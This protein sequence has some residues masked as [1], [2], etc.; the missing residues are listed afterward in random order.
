MESLDNI[1]SGKGEALPAPEV[2]EE[3]VAAPEQSEAAP[4]AEASEG[5]NQ[6][7]VP[8][9]ALHAEKQKVKRYTE[10]VADFRKQL[11]ESN[12]NWE[13]RIAQIL[14]SNKPAQ[15]QPQAP[16]F[17]ENPVEAT[18]HTVAPQFEQFS[19]QLLAIAKDNAIVRFTEE[20]VN[21]AEG[22]FLKAM[23]SQK[24]D[25]AD[26]HKVVNAPNR[27]AAAVQWHTRQQTLAE[28]G[29]DPTAFKER[30]RAQVLE[31]LKAEPPAG[32][33]P[34]APVMPS[35]LAGARNVGTRS[36]P[37]WAGPPTLADIFK[38]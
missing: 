27:Y 3:V 33:A 2:T 17:Y 23:Q 13:R 15:P 16:D 6:K 9:E 38:R 25:P 32:G 36:G 19:Q 26:Y 24:L 20:K 29:D 31:E 37:Q 14:E 10:E 22:A 21:E 1:L 5:G 34:V 35:N 4:E 7:M 18:R 8:H 28:I 11:D 12:A 30:I